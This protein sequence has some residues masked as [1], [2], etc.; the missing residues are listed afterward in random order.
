MGE[1]LFS[2]DYKSIA[3]FPD[4]SWKNE[5]AFYNGA[6]GKIN[7]Y[8]SFEYTID[9]LQKINNEVNLKI[10]SSTMAVTSNYFSYLKQR[11]D[12]RVEELNQLSVNACLLHD[13]VVY[14]NEPTDCDEKNEKEKEVI[15][16]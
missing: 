8:S 11:I 2:D 9:E 10:K 1:D 3:I 5:Y 13:N 15:S 12:A 4:G 14:Y 16:E 7:Y 6:T